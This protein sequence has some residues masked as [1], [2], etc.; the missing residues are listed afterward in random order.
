MKLTMIST[1]YLVSNYLFIFT[2]IH[3]HILINNLE[4]ISLFLVVDLPTDI[5]LEDEKDDM[6]E[7]A[8][9]KARKIKQKENLIT[10]IIKTEIK[11]PSEHLDSGNIILN[12]TAEF[13][14]TL[15]KF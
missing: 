5:K 8:L 4:V 3:V 1:M 14:R 12:A 2:R 7:K 10:D 15:G 11:E 9:H 13:C 6:L